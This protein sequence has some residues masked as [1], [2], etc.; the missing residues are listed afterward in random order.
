M[1][2]VG[3]GN[4]GTNPQSISPICSGQLLENLM[5]KDIDISATIFDSNLNHSVSKPPNIPK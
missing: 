3:I 2:A 1:R 4:H 5:S